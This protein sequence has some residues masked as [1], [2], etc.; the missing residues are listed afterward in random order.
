MA[1]E[2]RLHQGTLTDREREPWHLTRGIS[3]FQMATLAGTI[4]LGLMAWVNLVRDVEAGQKEQKSIVTSVKDIQ[5]KQNQVIIDIAV[6]RERQK[7]QNEENKEMKDDIKEILKAVR[8][9]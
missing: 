4:A 2:Q 6:I 7:Q 9:Q 3:L 1:D 5:V 8:K